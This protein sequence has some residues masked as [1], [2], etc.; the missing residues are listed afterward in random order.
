MGHCNIKKT[1]DKMALILEDSNRKE[2]KRGNKEEED[3]DKVTL[4]EKNLTI[5]DNGHETLDY[6]V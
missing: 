2:T 1:L 5:R 3:M 4:V 6:E